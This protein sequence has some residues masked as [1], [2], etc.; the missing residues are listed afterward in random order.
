M[1]SRIAQTLR[2]LS[3]KPSLESDVEASTVTGD[4]DQTVK[5]EVEEAQTETGDAA[6]GEAE[7]QELSTTTVEVAEGAETETAETVATDSE[8]VVS[9]ESED[10][11]APAEGE[12]DA[13]TT[14]GDGE[15]VVEAAVEEAQE[16]PADGAGAPGED[17]Q[18]EAVVVEVAEGTDTESAET[19][20]SGDETVSQEGFGG[21]MKAFGKTWAIGLRSFFSLKGGVGTAKAYA[22]LDVEQKRE[23]DKLKKKIDVI[24]KRLV[25]FREGDRKKAV[26]EGTKVPDS[27]LAPLDENELI[28]AVLKGQYIPFYTTYYGHKV[29]SLEGELNAKLAELAKLIDNVSTESIEEDLGPLLVS[30]EGFKGAFKAF[31]K[32]WGIA[33]RNVFSDDGMFTNAAKFSHFDLEQKRRAEELKQKIQ[34]LS[35]RIADY[36]DGD[37]AA[38]EKAGIRVPA[39]ELKD[40]DDEQIIDVIIKGQF[41]PFYTTYYGHKVESLEKD[42]NKKMAEL[43]QL[44]GSNVSTESEDDAATADAANAAAVAAAAAVAEGAAAAAEAAAAA[45]Q[46]VTGEANAEGDAVAAAAEESAAEATDTATEVAGEEAATPAEG[47]DAEDQAIADGEA[48]IEALEGDIADGEAHA[49]EYEQAAATMESLIEALED[50][51]KTGGLTPQSAR[52]F[53]IGFESIGVR[54]TGKPFEN[55]RGEAAIPSME[56][57][58]GTMRRDHATQ[59]SMEA[60][61]DWLKKILEVLKKTFA[62]IVEWVKKFVHAVF[63]QAERFNQRADAILEATKKLNGVKPKAASFEFRQAD[64]IANGKRV[65]IDSLDML[66]GVAAFA[67]EYAQGGQA[68]AD[69]YAKVI[70]D[71]AAKLKTVTDK[72]GWKSLLQGMMEHAFANFDKGGLDQMRSGLF[73]H[74]RTEG[75]NIIFGTETLPGN[76]VLEM[77]TY[78]SNPDGHKVFEEGAGPFIK[79][80]FSSMTKT[81]RT[82][83]KPTDVE[84]SDSDRE[85]PTLSV[86]QIAQVA[87]NVKQVIAAAKDTQKGIDAMRSEFRAQVTTTDEHS[88]VAKTVIN[89]MA[90]NASKF[91][92]DYCGGVSKALK[93]AVGT[94]GV[95]LDYANASLKQYAGELSNDEK[96]AAAAAAA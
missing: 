59:I 86:G 24:S 61:G 52:F 1:T 93:Y 25:E 26:A 49:E 76:V 13:S 66:L 38:A 19:E 73:K 87:K 60:A 63:S 31:G 39:S 94:S 6:I 37:R 34:I 23:A 45:V 75:L 5:A 67:N 53:N 10:A 7:A 47:A 83:V 96:T 29:E 33:I 80:V 32:T 69:G 92:S 40:L 9:S 18:V 4:G 84:L 43:A 62:Q 65:D 55:A 72:E 56:S 42:L 16:T 71:A 12:V 3:L 2:G 81:G 78:E 15:Q 90:N 95:F 14:T 20:V 51:Q 91:I 50:A 41:I 21:A 36:R 58:G 28:I 30:T 57:F 64:K 82:F 89:H 11:A 17:Q 22:A 44:I 77:V 68:Y 48:E 8:V 85:L 70:S 54:L 88:A 74:R 35:K 27:Q 79:A 46:A